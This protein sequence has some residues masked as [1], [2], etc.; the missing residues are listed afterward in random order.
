MVPPRA[1]PTWGVG[2]GLLADHVLGVPV[3]PVRILL[4][5]EFLVFPM[6]GGCAP[7]RTSQ[8]GRRS[9]GGRS[10]IGTAGEPVR[11]L[12]QQPGVSVGI[13]EGGTREVAAPLRVEALDRTVR[14]GVED[15]ADLDSGCEQRGAGRLP[16]PRRS[17]I[18]CRNRARP[19]SGR[20]RTG[21]S[22]RSRGELDDGGRCPVRP[23]V[24]AAVEVPCP[25]H[26]RHRDDEHFDL[27]V[28][29]VH[30]HGSARF[31]GPRWV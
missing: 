16:R 8:I 14:S 13:T 7:Q 30:F 6:G 19:T 20:C 21:P 31:A 9:E 26:V 24:E 1:G 17:G 22:T 23:P 11:D 25:F 15:G 29:V 27:H 18:P 10:G 28:D 2:T 3:G 4:A 5:D 12:L